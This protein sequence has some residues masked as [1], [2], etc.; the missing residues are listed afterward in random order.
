MLSLWAELTKKSHHDVKIE[1]KTWLGFSKSDG[2]DLY[3]RLLTSKADGTTDWIWTNPLFVRWKQSTNGNSSDRLVCIVGKH[4]CGKSV[5]AATISNTL[6]KRD[7][8]HTLFFSFSGVEAGSQNPERLVR[9]ILWQLLD[10]LEDSHS[11]SIMKELMAKGSPL[12]SE[13]W[14][15]LQKAAKLIKKQIVCIIDGIDECKYTEKSP[16]KLTVELLQSHPHIRALLV[17]RPHVLNSVE[18]V[19]NVI[20]MAAETIRPEIEA[21]LNSEIDKSELLKSG[22]VR[23]LVFDNIIQGAEGMFLWAKLML[24]DL[25]RSNSRHEVRERLRKLPRGL[26]ETYRHLLLQL[27]DEL[28]GFELRLAQ[29]IISLSSVSYRRFTLEEIRYACALKAKAATS[30]SEDHALQ[31]YLLSKPAQSIGKVCRGLIAI[32]DGAISLTHFSAKEFLTRP[33][34]EWVCQD[35]IRIEGFRVDLDQSNASLGC[36]CIDYIQCSDFSDHLHE[37]DGENEQD[38]KHPFLDYACKY[39]THHFCQSTSHSKYTGSKVSN[40]IRSPKY[41]AW[42]DLY[43]CMSNSEQSIAHELDSLA[44]F[45]TW[46]SGASSDEETNSSAITS[47]PHQSEHSLGLADA[48]EQVK[49]WNMIIEAFVGLGLHRS[50]TSGDIRSSSDSASGLQQAGTADTREV[51]N[52]L[53]KE[54]KLSSRWHVR[55]SHSLMTS[56]LPLSKSDL[57]KLIM[58]KANRI[59]PYVLVSAGIRHLI[60][61]NVEE[62]IEVLEAGLL[63]LQGQDN[64]LRSFALF[65]MGSAYQSLGQYEKALQYATD[66]EPGIR[67]YCGSQHTHTMRLSRDISYLYLMNGDAR[68]ALLWAKKSFDGL[69]AIFGEEHHETLLAM[70]IL[71]ETYNSLGEYPTAQEWTE[72]ARRTSAIIH[73]E[74]DSLTLNLTYELGKTCYRN[75]Y[76]KNALQWLRNVY[77]EY[78]LG[79]EPDRQWASKSAYEIA[80]V[81]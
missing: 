49:P 53:T 40:F 60:E 34:A 50:S 41:V 52:A 58:Q 5:L 1:F 70:N 51:I 12:M 55:L 6:S 80:R 39:L 47:K 68:A 54:G 7:D 36:L 71:R 48:E 2:R 32:D 10:T 23:Q 24:G 78:K 13:L 33:E 81:Y 74:S 4:G 25:Q 37:F 19:E 20:Q 67:K 45:T 57:F 56:A 16:I 44:Q 22:E 77:Q 11:C 30:N 15:A 79:D 3:H 65:L 31:E 26:A 9:S 72:R 38:E 43:A 62:S 28:D 46:V 76:N 66:S 27:V 8:Q 61:G 64:L 59:S 42:L 35:D 69:R 14:E 17:A 75:G 18:S 21:F 63:K 29:T 73:G